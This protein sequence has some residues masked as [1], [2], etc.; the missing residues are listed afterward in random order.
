MEL[1][2][3]GFVPNAEPNEWEVA[4]ETLS[5]KL[6]LDPHRNVS[7]MAPMTYALR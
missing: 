6:Y 5:E 3:G 7:G 1:A 2:P 4:I